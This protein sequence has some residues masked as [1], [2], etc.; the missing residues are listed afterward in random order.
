M[1][2]CRVA[3]GPQSA[4][5]AD[6]AQPLQQPPDG[7]GVALE[8]VLGGR[9]AVGGEQSLLEIP[10]NP[11][12]ARPDD[13]QPGHRA[14]RAVQLGHP[15]THDRRT[16]RQHG[17]EAAACRLQRGVAEAAMQ[18]GVDHQRQTVIDDFERGDLALD[19]SHGTAVIVEDL[20]QV[21][22]HGEAEHDRDRPE[23]A[24]VVEPIEQA[25][26]RGEEGA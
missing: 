8:D 20:L 4:R 15:R 11:L 13:L 2:E 24:R 3:I 16:H 1:V 18:L 22:R 14:E 9:P 6:I 21:Q 23:L 19:R 10:A 17:R 12:P 25:H 26:D 7:D 5:V